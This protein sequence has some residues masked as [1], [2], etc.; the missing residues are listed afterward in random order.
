MILEVMQRTFVA[1]SSDVVVNTLR[2]GAASADDK[3]IGGLLEANGVEPADVAAAAAW[4]ESIRPQLGAEPRED[5]AYLPGDREA[6]LMQS[7]LQ[8]YFIVRQL[9]EH[10]QGAGAGPVV[11]PISDV[12]LKGTAAQTQPSQLFR[13][14]QQLDVGWASCLFAKAYGMVGKRHPFRDQPAA[15]R[16]I[17]DDAR[18][19]VI[20]DWGSGVARAKKITDRIRS[21]MLEETTREQ[22]VIHL[23]DVYYSGW[24]EEYD[25]HFLTNWPVRSGEERRYG[26]WCLNANH[27]MFSGGQAYFEYLLRDARFLAQQ[28]SSYFSLATNSWQIL[29]LDSAWTEGSL[30]G[31]QLEW[32]ADMQKKAP[33]KKLMLMT[34]HQPFSAFG[35]KSYPDL[36]ALLARNRVTAWYWGHEHRFALY[37]SRPDLKY[38]RLL[39]HSGVPVWQNAPWKFWNS[40]TPDDVALVGN[41]SFRSG[42]E[43]FSLF[44]FAVLDFQNEAIRARYIYENGDEEEPETLT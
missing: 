9:V 38:G 41:K 18:V 40:K 17:A 28:G 7:A 24:P 11:N 12:S 43:S 26:S 32:V 39:G 29:G 21:M 1:D 30:A 22:H 27:D 42:V 14:M 5:A 15:P 13:P 34:H 31:G 25:E 19:Y 44:G 35:E 23:G 2:Q 16:T 10:P 8:R 20:G 37:R 3:V 33:N 36:Q 6:S 4:V